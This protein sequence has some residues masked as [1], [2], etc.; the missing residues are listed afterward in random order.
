VLRGERMWGATA[1]LPSPGALRLG[2]RPETAGRARYGTDGADSM[3]DTTFAAAS[4][5]ASAITLT[6]STLK[7]VRVPV[8]RRPPLPQTHEASALCELE[9]SY[10]ETQ[11]E[12]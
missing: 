6:L 1:Q 2:R 9:A 3:D 12:A 5:A 8:A 10:R 7:L 4:N 11:H